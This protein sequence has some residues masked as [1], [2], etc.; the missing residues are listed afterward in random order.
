[1]F[2]NEYGAEEPN[3]KSDVLYKIAQ[4]LI[5]SGVPFDGVG[6]QFH[7]STGSYPDAGGMTENLRRFADLGL[8]VQITEGDVRNS[9]GERNNA[10][11]R[12][13]QAD[14]FT[15]GAKACKRVVACDRFTLWGLSD[16]YSWLGED[17]EPLPFDAQMKSK[18]AWAA[19]TEQLRPR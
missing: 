7:A 12:Q 5:A 9:T 2:L 1:M 18:P 17:K 14:A 10:E 19:I 6:F 16:R 11:R 8:A 4:T 15:A 3:Q 13:Q